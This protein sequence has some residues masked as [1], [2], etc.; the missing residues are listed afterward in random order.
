M[1]SIPEQHEALSPVK[2]AL[3]A[4]QA[5]QARLDAVE[6]AGKEPIAVI[7]IGCRFPGG[8][9]SPAAFWQLLAAGADAIAEV[10]LGRWDIDAYYDPDPG[11]P[12]KISTRYGG[13]LSDVDQFD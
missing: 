10:P 5:M 4:L 2:R 9:N 8:A 11:A 6:R 12:G 7:G 13:F 3:S 1:S